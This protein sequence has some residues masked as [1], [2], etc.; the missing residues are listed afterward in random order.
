MHWF[1]VSLLSSV[2]E[3]TPETWDTLVTHSNKHVFVKFYAPWCGHCKK[4]KPDWDKLGETSDST[5][6]GDVDCTGNGKPLCEK[7]NI[8]GFPTLKSFWGTF[9][10]DYKGGRS[11]N[12]LLNFANNLKIPCTVEHKESCSKS[13]L[14]EIEEVLKLTATQKKDMLETIQTQIKEE[15][16]NHEKL[17]KS[18]QSQYESSQSKLD[19]LKK[20][21]S[22]KSGI[23]EHLIQNTKD[24]L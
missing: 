11:Y 5:M 14:T 6:I 23:L 16:M 9:S 1:I 19:E 8:Q 4:L 17:L 13:Q 21:A 3:L 12:E 20:E 7:F 2:V 22:F 10:E 18:L 24:E 15:E